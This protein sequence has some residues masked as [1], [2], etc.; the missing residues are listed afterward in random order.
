MVQDVYNPLMCVTTL[1]QFPEK[2]DEH[3]TGFFYNYNDRTYL[4]TNRHVIEHEHEQPTQISIR[5]RNH[6]DISSTNREEIP[7][8]D[9]EF[10]RWLIHP[11]YPE[12]D[13]TAIPLN[14]RL[15]YVNEKNSL[16]GSLALSSD[17]FANEG[18]LIRG[19]TGA[20]AFGYPDGY[21]DKNSQFPIARNGMIASPYGHH[22]DGKPQLL[23]DG[24]M[25]NGM[26]GSPVFTERTNSFEKVDGNSHTAAPSSFLIGIHSGEFY[27][28]REAR[29]SDLSLNQVWYSELIEEL[30]VYNELCEYVDEVP[31]VSNSDRTENEISKSELSDLVTNFSTWNFFD[32]ERNQR[33]SPVEDL[34]EKVEAEGLKSLISL[35]QNE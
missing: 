17:A 8:Y 35:V 31:F 22:F 30:L 26:S 25:G 12:A 6:S 9:N 33:T 28:S 4:I 3:A 21:I 34:E 20:R 29:E 7:L 2:R 18:L 5:F 15:S 24:V 13:I 1:L 14:Q 23:I 27:D 32:P 11:L 16:T 10:P 19:G